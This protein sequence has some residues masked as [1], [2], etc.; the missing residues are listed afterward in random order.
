MKII[1]QGTKEFKFRIEY[2]RLEKYCVAFVYIDYEKTSTC[3][4][5]ETALNDYDDNGELIPME[6]RLKEKLNQLGFDVKEI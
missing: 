3:V 2:E 4:H 1:L 5:I 6:L